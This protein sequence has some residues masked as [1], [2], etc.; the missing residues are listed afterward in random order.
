MGLIYQAVAG[1]IPFSEIPKGDI[2][3]FLAGMRAVFDREPQV[4][5]VSEK[6]VFAGDTHSDHEASCKVLHYLGR[7]QV[8]FL[9]DYVDRA[10]RPEDDIR[11]ILL[12]FLK[13]QQ[14]PD[15]ILLRG[16]HEDPVVNRQYGFYDSV[17]AFW[18]KEVF[19]RFNE[20]FL[21]MP[22]VVVND[23]LIAC[24]GGLPDAKNLTELKKISKGKTADE[25]PLVSQLLWNDHVN[26]EERVV[27]TDNRGVKHS[28]CTGEPFFLEVMKRLKKKL[29]LRA[30]DPLAKGWLY[31]KR[32]LTLMTSSWY[33][34]LPDGKGVSE[35]P[36]SGR[37]IAVVDGDKVTVRKI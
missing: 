33:A 10:K 3:C 29:L 17:C 18:D 30:H 37:T 13:K 5:N 14:Y 6:V 32:C 20:V 24:H 27:R 21:R 23:H 19:D 12:L 25:D 8:V 16:N 7:R 2:L 28:L 4:I 22:L 36:I 9:G 11:N 1:K 26:S 15:L 35:H 31:D 34:H